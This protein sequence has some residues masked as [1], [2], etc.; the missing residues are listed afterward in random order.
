[1]YRNDQQVYERMLNIDNHQ[2]NANHNYN[3]LFFSL[4]NWQ[5]QE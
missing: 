5:D 1:M 3:E 2:E 4:S